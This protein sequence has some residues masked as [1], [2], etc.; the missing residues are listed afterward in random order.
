[1]EYTGLCIESIPYPKGHKSMYLPHSCKYQI[2]DILIICNYIFKKSFWKDYIPLFKE[3][4]FYV[5]MWY[6]YESSCFNI[7]P[8]NTAL[9]WPNVGATCLQFCSLQISLPFPV[10][11]FSLWRVIFLLLGWLVS[12]PLSLQ[13]M[14]KMPVGA[15]G[16]QAWHELDR[17]LGQG[18]PVPRE[19]E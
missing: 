1:M 2:P 17:K 3:Q 18:P 13:E 9:G 14:F 11:C 8:Y 19:L 5:N 7:I 10:F 12:K 15:A 4:I 6:Y 16:D